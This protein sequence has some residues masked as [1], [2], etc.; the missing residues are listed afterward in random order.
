M[1]SHAVLL[2]V[3]MHKLAACLIGAKARS[4]VFV[5]LPQ[6]ESGRPEM[7]KVYAQSF[8]KP[9]YTPLPLHPLT[10]GP[11]RAYTGEPS[12]AVINKLQLLVVSYASR[13]LSDGKWQKTARL[14]FSTH[15]LMTTS[16][17]F[18]ESTWYHLNRQSPTVCCGEA[19]MRGHGLCTWH[20][21]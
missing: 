2:A 11:L 5:S 15:V 1:S 6:R 12:Y 16:L 18:F 20:R 7:R 10:Q 14:P 3:C 8:L 4:Q 13:P 19:I 17:A 9:Q 21:L